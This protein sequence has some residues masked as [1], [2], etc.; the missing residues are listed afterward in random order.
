MT[1]DSS[2]T[3]SAITYA[4]AEG[5][6]T[7]CLNRPEARNGYT[8][9]MAHELEHALSTADADPDVAVVVLSCVG[10]D[11]SV[12]ADLSGG[13]F[14]A[15]MPAS[16]AGDWQEPAGRCSKTIFGL[17]KPVIAA[18][19][20]VSVGGGI[21]ITLSCDF[22]LAAHDSRFSFPFS[23]RGIFPEGASVWYLPRLVG[24]SR[25]TDW[26][27][28]GRLF[29]AQEAL[30]AGLVTSLHPPEDVL[31]AAYSLARDIIANTS[32]VSTAVIKQMLNHL[33]GLNSPLPV[34]ALDSKLIA[35]LPGHG[36]AVEGVTSF[37]EKRPPRFPLQVPQDLPPWLPW[38]EAGQT[39]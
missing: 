30:D 28:T 15:I 11:F 19:R 7:L 38:L 4:V 6:A 22:R 14:D 8:L 5:I 2:G 33:S 24:M 29:D 16:P 20:G 18:L 35:G 3:Y 32:A 37:L 39:P 12:G 10:R 34:H 23:R 36:D 9:A 17:N 21:T 1:M 27:L 31:E 13:G 25:A 26:M